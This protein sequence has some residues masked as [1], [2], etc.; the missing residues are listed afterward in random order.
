MRMTIQYDKATISTI[1]NDL[2]KLQQPEHEAVAIFAKLRKK[3]SVYP[4]V[5]LLLAIHYV[6]IHEHVDY[7]IIQNFIENVLEVTVTDYITILSEEHFLNVLLHENER[8]RTY[9]QSLGTE[10]EKNKTER[11]TN[12]RERI[13]KIVQAL[14]QLHNHFHVKEKLIFPVLERFGHVQ[15]TRDIWRED[16]YI[17]GAYRAVKN[18]LVDQAS[19][20]MANINHTFQSFSEKL[21][22]MFLQEEYI[23]FPITLQLFRESEWEQIK[24]ESE[25]YG[26]DIANADEKTLKL[27]SNDKN[28]KIATHFTDE[29]QKRRKTEN[30]PFGKGYLTLEEADLI[31]N[32][33]PVEITFVDRNSIFKYFNDV[34]AAQDMMLIRT[35]L[36]IGRNVAHCHPPKSLRKVMT[37]VRDLKTKKRTTETM[38]FKKGDTY[39]HITYKG[40][41]NETG[42]FI[43]ILE[44][45]QNISSFLQLPTEEK[46]QLTKIDK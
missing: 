22:K 44:Y 17:R 27:P 3:Y 12:E 43:G 39:V 21:E 4:K 24:N 33:L 15:F 35:P 30:I 45:V 20:N 14:G 32:N 26:Y 6:L 10:I 13:R 9:L 31:L 41:F 11:W 2:L 8:Y 37:L 34:H 5:P 16:D 1:K 23:L 18:L 42:E 38:W 19:T 46:R 29:Q 25:A 28:S 36:S 7:R 40:L